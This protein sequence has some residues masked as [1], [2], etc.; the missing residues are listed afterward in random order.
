MRLTSTANTHPSLKDRVQALGCSVESLAC[1]GFPARPTPSAAERWFADQV[2]DIR[3]EVSEIWVKD[4]SD[5]W[6]SRHGRLAAQQRQITKLELAQTTNEEAA[7]EI[8]WAKAQALFDTHDVDATEQTLRQLLALDPNHSRANMALGHMLLGR[9]LIEGQDFLLQILKEE[10]NDLI[11]DA[12]TALSNFYQASGQGDRVAQVHHRLSLYQQA[13]A[14]GQRER[15]AVT[16]SDTFIAHD[17]SPQELIEL[18][19]KLTEIP[20]L[21]AAYLVRKQLKHFTKQPLFVLCVHTTPGLFGL[22]A[23]LNSQLASRVGTQIKLPGRRFV[24][25]PVLGFKALGKKVMKSP[26]SRIV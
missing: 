2:N 19:A 12:C 4:V 17:L 14:A 5:N 23:S 16:A 22:N 11:P 9:G 3:R 1:D 18:T 8:L 25:S 7:S 26:D 15:N 24:I 10:E 13:V 6:K 21:F 20:D